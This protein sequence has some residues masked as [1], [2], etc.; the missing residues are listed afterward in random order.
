[1][2]SSQLRA[3][4]MPGQIRSVYISS[5]H[6]RLIRY[7]TLRRVHLMYASIDKLGNTNKIIPHERAS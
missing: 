2:F 4:Q 6:T 1:M 5:S 7:S 3:D